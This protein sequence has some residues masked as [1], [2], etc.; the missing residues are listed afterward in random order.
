MGLLNPLTVAWRLAHVRESI[1]PNVLLS[2]SHRVC[3]LS[4]RSTV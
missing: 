4:C 1:H 3:I 2:V